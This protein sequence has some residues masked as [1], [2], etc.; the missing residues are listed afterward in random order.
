MV[1]NKLNL[2]GAYLAIFILLTS[3]LIFIFRLTHQQIAEYWTGIAF[4]LTAIP[5]VYLIFSSTNFERP[6][7]YYIQ[8]GLMLGFIIVELFLDYVLKVD[9]RQ[10]RWIVIFYVTM[11]F[12][13]TG[14][15]IG[16]A[17]QAGKYWTILAIILFLI[18]TALAFIQ[19]AKTGL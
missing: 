13:S 15:M 1:I 2:I 4:M 12:A 17:S 14:G 3:S 16:I 19:R 8:L 6:T 5:I 7:F 18:M 10:T 9:F 11:F